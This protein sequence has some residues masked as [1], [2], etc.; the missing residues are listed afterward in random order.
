MSVICLPFLYSKRTIKETEKALGRGRGSS[1]LGRGALLSLT[2]GHHAGDDGHGLALLDV[3]SGD[4]GHCFA[5][6]RK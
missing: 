1:R 4:D 5:L 3:D 6:R 2:L